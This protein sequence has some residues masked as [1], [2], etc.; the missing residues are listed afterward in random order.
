[1][2]VKP[3][4]R[5]QPFVVQRAPLKQ[6]GIHQVAMTPSLK[7]SNPNAPLI[8]FEEFQPKR[9]KSF[10]YDDDCFSDIGIVHKT[11]VDPPQN[12]DLE[13]DR[14]FEIGCHVPFTQQPY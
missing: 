14:N 7:F 6:P 11:I 9:N 8:Q 3:E 5:L 13:I 1:M 4:G 10:D 2:E 12:F